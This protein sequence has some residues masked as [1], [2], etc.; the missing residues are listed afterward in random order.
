MTFCWTGLG[1]TV[2]Q[3]V[4][5]TKREA[6]RAQAVAAAERGRQLNS[7][8]LLATNA[9]THKHQLKSLRFFSSFFFRL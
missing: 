8:T 2:V 5:G 1:D 9:H 6:S 3:V 7:S 4:T